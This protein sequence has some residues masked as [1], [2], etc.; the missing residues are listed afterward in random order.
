MNK[1]PAIY[2]LAALL[3]TADGS[4]S[5]SND[6]KNWVPARPIGYWSWAYRLKAAWLVWT[7]R[8]DAV[9]WPQGQ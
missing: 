1:T 5:S 6:G 3:N 8:A 9:I 4:N 7:G 2:T